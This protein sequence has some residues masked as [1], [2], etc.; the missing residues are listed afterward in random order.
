MLLADA[1]GQPCGCF[2]DLVAFM[3]FAFD[4]HDVG[5]VA[6]LPADIKDGSI[7]RWSKEALQVVAKLPL[8]DS[9]DEKKLHMLSYIFET[10][11]DLIIEPRLNVSQSSLS[12]SL[13]LSLTHTHT[14]T[15]TQPHTRTHADTQ[16]THVCTQ[17]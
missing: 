12:L 10:I 14:R 1:V 9:L 17:P 2:P 4:K 5:G 3:D 15:H 16:H 8:G 11:D 7:M 13:S 6:I